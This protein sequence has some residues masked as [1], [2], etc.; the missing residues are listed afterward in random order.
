MLMWILLVLL[1][2]AGWIGYLYLVAVQPTTKQEGMTA[3]AASDEKLWI[4]GET[5]D[6]TKWPDPLPSSILI[7]G[8]EPKAL[9]LPSAEDTNEEMVM[10]ILNDSTLIQ[11]VQGNIM[12][13]KK[14]VTL[15]PGTS[16][17]FR[18]DGKRW[19]V[20]S[21]VRFEKKTP[22]ATATTTARKGGPLR[23]KK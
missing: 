17:A 11:P 15:E 19:M 3:P 2:A 5:V 4:V 10:M 23:H 6:P 14:V 20:L 16:K 7:Q 12:S 1:I 22:A 9:T 18:S 13:G 21:S 8:S